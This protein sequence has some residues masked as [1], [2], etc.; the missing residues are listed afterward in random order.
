M[1]LPVESGGENFI[2]EL[3]GMG[4]LFVYPEMFGHV[5]LIGKPP[6]APLASVR[7]LTR[8]GPLV[9]SKMITPS[10]LLHALLALVGPLTSVGFSPALVV[11]LSKVTSQSEPLFTLLALVGPLTSVG[12]L[13]LSK[14]TSQSEPL[15]TLLALVGPLTSVGPLV[16]SKVTSPSEPLFTLLALVG[17]LTSVGPWW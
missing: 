13:V 4:C 10:E 2:T 14:F 3:A 9:L 12:P 17:P 1:S 6:T 16:L 11:I 5:I 15:F 7:P 8:V